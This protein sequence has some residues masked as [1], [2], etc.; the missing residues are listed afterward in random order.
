MRD[1]F[2]KYAEQLQEIISSGAVSISNIK[3]HAWTEQNVIMGR[4]FP[5]P[6]RYSRTP[7]CR[8]IIDTFS[9]DH[10][11]KWLAV[12]KGAQIGLSAGV[13]IP[14]QLWMIKNDPCNTYFLVGSP[15]LIEKATEKLDIGI[16][17]AGLRKYIK[18]QVKRRKSQKT[19]DTNNKKEFSGGYIHIGSANNHKDIRDVSLKLGLFDDWE[20]VKSKS[21][22]SGNSRKLLEQ[23]FAAYASSHKIAYVSTPELEENSNIQPAYLLGDQRKYLIPCPCC[24]QHIELLWSVTIGEKTG[25]ITWKLDENNRLISDSVG[26]I[27]QLCGEF[28]D[29]KN[30]SEW[31]L[32]RGFGGDAY[33]QPTAQPSK[34]GYYSYHISSLY[35][36]LGMFDWE[37]YVNDYLEANP[38]GGERDED[39]W[40]TFVNVVLGQTYKNPATEIRA[41]AL[42]KNCRNYPINFIPEQISIND[43]NGKI[44]LVTCACDLNGK[45]EDARLDFEVVAHSE[46]GA[47]YSVTHGSIG[48]FIPNESNKKNKVEREKWTYE[49]TRPNNVWKEFNKLLGTIFETDTGRKMKIFITAIDTGY[50]ELQAFTYIDSTNFYVLG[51]KGDKDDKYIDQGID[52]PVFKV[53]HSRDKLYML[54]VGKIKDK[55]AALI[56]LRWDS[57]NDDAQ[58]PGFMNFPTPS[59]GLYMFSNYFAH[60]ESE[61]RVLDKD[62]KFIW[63]KKTATAQNHLFDCRIYNLAIRDILLFEI[64]KSYKVK[65]Y[66]WANFCKDA[67]GVK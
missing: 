48:T 57:S 26:Y 16:D 12:M 33:W 53:G 45:L 31:L 29:D 39:L 11:M 27:C 21:K 40:K 14:I 52:T 4:P 38:E 20:S 59:A 67:L 54:R 50:C 63:E 41:N 55:L 10:P 37:H 60:F 58:P 61:Q 42:Q 62:N 13:L 6:Y 3:P 34:P 7:Y 18:P 25:G 15:E 8:E 19:G 5:G 43:G 49:N 32:E 1:N 2:D 30:K 56:N 51:I 44:V 46:S 28:F 22:E 35:A 17:N 23:R 47:T 24:K 66:D 64:A 65:T 36:P 9:Q